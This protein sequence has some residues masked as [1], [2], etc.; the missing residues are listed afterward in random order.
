M[1]TLVLR[2]DPG[3]TDVDTWR[4]HDNGRAI[5]IRAKVARLEVA[6]DVELRW[7][8]RSATKWPDAIFA[9][10]FDPQGTIWLTRPARLGGGL[11]DRELQLKRAPEH[12]SAVLFGW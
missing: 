10:P 6:G 9:R 7:K 2:Y 8:A 11:L 5:Q 3:L 4:L 12:V 1:T